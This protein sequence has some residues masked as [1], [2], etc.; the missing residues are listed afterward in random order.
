MSK[1]SLEEFAHVET[2]NDIVPFQYMEPEKT[3][4]PSLSEKLIC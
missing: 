2:I 1:N 3:F 4:G